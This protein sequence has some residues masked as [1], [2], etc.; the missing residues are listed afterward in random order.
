MALDPAILDEL[1]QL[2]TQYQA[3]ASFMNMPYTPIGSDPDLEGGGS[4]F[5]QIGHASHAVWRPVFRVDL[6][7]RAPAGAD[8]L[9]RHLL[10]LGPTRRHQAR[11]RRAE[12]PD[13]GRGGRPAASGG[14]RASRQPQP[15]SCPTG[16]KCRRAGA[17]SRG[18]QVGRAAAAQAARVR[19]AAIAGA[20]HG[21][22]PTSSTR[23]SGPVDSTWPTIRA[24]ACRCWRRPRSNRPAMR[25][26]HRRRPRPAPS[27][28]SSPISGSPPRPPRARPECR[29]SRASRSPCRA[30]CPPRRHPRCRPATPTAMTTSCAIPMAGQPSSSSLAARDRQGYRHC[31]LP[32]GSQLFGRRQARHGCRRACH[33]GRQR[34]LEAPRRARGYRALGSEPERQR[35]RSERPRDPRFAQPWR[36]SG[37]RGSGGPAPMYEHPGN[38]YQG[39]ADPRDPRHALAAA[40]AGGFRNAPMAETFVGE[41]VPYG[42]VQYKKVVNAKMDCMVRLWI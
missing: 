34:A 31:G 12:E 14:G 4:P 29:P 8:A 16:C 17:S 33:K 2:A 3:P 25:S 39:K 32:D 20:D 11:R 28:T 9:R 19:A 23:S 18:P 10:W 41:L 37:E 22:H 7:F 36:L 27:S 21:R 13:A 5:G 38:V 35:G 15:S 30:C 42:L 26:R 6:L 1:Y 24:V 40:G